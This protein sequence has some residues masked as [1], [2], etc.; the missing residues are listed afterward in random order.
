MFARLDRSPALK[1]VARRQRGVLRRR[2]LLAAGIGAHEVMANIEAERWTALGEEVVLLQNAPPTHEQLMWI[3]VLDAGTC[4]LGSHTSLELVGFRPFAQESEQV[5]LV[6]PRG[7]KVTRFAGVVVHESRRLKPEEILFASG[8]PRTPTARS[9]LD[10][11]AWQPFPRFAVTM[12]AAAVQQRVTSAAQLECAL[13]A[14]GRIRHKQVL[15]ETIRDVASG[16]QSLGEVELAKLCRHRGLVEPNR[17][18]PRR[19]ASGGWR[20]LD[21]EWDLESGEHVVL[22]VDGGYHMDAG[23]W[24]ADIVRERSI[25]V[26]GKRVI[27]TTNY[28]VR[29]DPEPLVADLLALGVP[30]SQAV[31]T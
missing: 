4:A 11:A 23:Q 5:H 30:P 24:E 20:F 28:E 8:L 16:A 1:S 3:A 14:V 9:V 2:Q 7:D 13:A 21:A 19:D 10:A 25:V 17:Q 29:H 22:E 15:R 31:S 26:G 18:R 12:V 6:V 27:R